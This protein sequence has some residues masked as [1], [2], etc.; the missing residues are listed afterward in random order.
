MQLRAAPQLHA[1]Q[2]PTEQLD[3]VTV[4]QLSF[5]FSHA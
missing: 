2:S 5:V 1:E 4:F 3:L